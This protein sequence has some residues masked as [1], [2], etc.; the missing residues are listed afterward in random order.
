MFFESTNKINIGS[1]IA[2]AHKHL[3]ISH[4]DYD[5]VLNHFNSSVINVVPNVPEDVL[6]KLNEILVWI[7]FV[8]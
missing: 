3:K 4:D 1:P 8:L 2:E 5:A 6:I 7:K